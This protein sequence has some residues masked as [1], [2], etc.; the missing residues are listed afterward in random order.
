[1]FGP[2]KMYFFQ[3]NDK[4]DFNLFVSFIYEIVKS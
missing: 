2:L 1:M 3:L 4:N